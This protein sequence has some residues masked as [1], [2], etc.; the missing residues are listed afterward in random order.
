MIEPIKPVQ[1]GIAM[2]I[3]IAGLNLVIPWESWFGQWWFEKE[4]FFIVMVVMWV[5]IITWSTM[6]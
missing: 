4:G 2:N 3:I 5:T 6:L 1:I